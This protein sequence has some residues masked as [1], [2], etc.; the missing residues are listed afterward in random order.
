MRTRYGEIS[1][2]FF[3]LALFTGVIW[4]SGNDVEP[5]AF[6]L[7]TISAL[8]FTSPVIARYVLPDRKLVRDMSY[9]EILGFITSSKLKTR[10]EM[11]SYKLGGRSLP[12]RRSSLA[13]QGSL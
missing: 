6:V 10:L 5:I 3:T 2:I 8:L 11:D 1:F 4:I 7:G 13:L 9:D 12:E